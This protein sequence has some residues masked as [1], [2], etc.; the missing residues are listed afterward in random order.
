MSD[1]C[2]SLEEFERAKEMKCRLLYVVGQL[3]RG[4]L[5]RQLFYLIQAMTRE[6]Y[7]PVVA[8]RSNSSDDHYAQGLRALNVPVVR[9]GNNSTWSVKL[10]ALCG[11]VSGS[12][13]M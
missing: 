11:L 5:E 9:L 4:G 2:P 6:R 12:D 7:K 8:V 1:G 13:R 10:K 3:G